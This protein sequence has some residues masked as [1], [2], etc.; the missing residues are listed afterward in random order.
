M[1]KIVEY[2]EQAKV[3]V[4]KTAAELNVNDFI[5]TATGCG[6]DTSFTDLIDARENWNM[7]SVG[8]LCQIVDIIDVE[9]DYEFLEG[10]LGRPAP[11]HKGGSQSDDIDESRDQ[12]SLTSDDYATFYDLITVYRKPSGK[13]IGVDCQGYD[14]WRYVH[15]PSNYESLFA[16]ERSE[17]LDRLEKKEQEREAKK[18]EELAQHAKALEDRENE[19]K[20]KYASLVLSPANGRIVGNNI[21]KFLGIEFPEVKF[22][23]SVKRSYWG[24]S[25]DVNVDVIGVTEQDKKDHIRKVC[26]VWTDTMPTGRM[27]DF[28]DY[29]GECESHRCPMAI[30]GI[31]N[32]SISFIFSEA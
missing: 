18:L 5:L 24:S 30:F 32:N 20:S 25:Y 22:K 26:K 14:Y 6:K 12:Y 11:A 13:W 15:I 9:E 28:N 17:A 29:K 1:K 21:R 4:N 8:R 7:G 31:I 27:T 23:V 2:K 3:N 10:W 19:L 16:D